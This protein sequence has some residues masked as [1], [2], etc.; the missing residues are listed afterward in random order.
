VTLKFICN[1][2]LSSLTT[3]HIYMYIHKLTYMALPQRSGG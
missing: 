3:V 1:I 2:T